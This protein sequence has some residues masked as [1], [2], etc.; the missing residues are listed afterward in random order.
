[1][2]VRIPEWLLKEPY[3][4]VHNRK[5]RPPFEVTVHKSE[6]DFIGKGSTLCEA[7]KEAVKKRKM[8]ENKTGH[9][10]NGVRNSSA[11]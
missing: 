5:Q 10:V 9:E 6:H 2:I 11:E 8:F 4:V 7:A 3:Q 1:M